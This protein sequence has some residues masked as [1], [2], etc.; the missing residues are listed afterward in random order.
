LLV[1]IA[2]IALLV[3]LLLPAVQQAREAARRSQCQNNLKQLGLAIF[4]YES[5]YTR[6]PSSG[7]ST[8]EQL[9]VR[10]WF[11]VS[12]FTAVLPYTDQASVYNQWNM[13]LHYTNSANSSNATLAQTK[14]PAYVCP[15]NGTTQPDALNYGNTD[16]FPIAYTDIDPITGLRNKS[17]AGNLNAEVGG[18]LGFGRRI[19]EITDGLSNTLLVIEM[20]GR[21]TQLSGHFIES[22]L[23][24]GGGPGLDTTQ[25]FAKA[26]TIGGAF[27]GGIDAPYRWADPNTGAG[28]SGPPTQDPSSSLYIGGSITQVINNWKAPAGGPAECPWNNN[29][30]GPNN[31]PF[32]MHSGGAQALLGDGRVRFV[33]ESTN[34]QIIRMLANRKDCGVI[35]DF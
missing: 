13:N 5:T 30:C 17:V 10:Q 12:M 4:N 18:A 16:Y 20:S 6:M 9:L 29:N 23:L 14:I 35:G 33:N 19:S 7:A 2:I 27:G 28:I 15:S 21:P 25:L 22:Q 8:N 26:D 31:E 32:S 24:I 11:P 34:I 3:A 1:V